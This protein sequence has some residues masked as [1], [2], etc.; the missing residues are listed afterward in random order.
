MWTP[1]PGGKGTVGDVARGDAAHDCVVLVELL[2][3]VV[4]GQQD[5][6]ARD[7]IA[8]TLNSVLATLERGV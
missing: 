4:G 7:N 1:C 8:L 3:T 6:Q 5:D 2:N